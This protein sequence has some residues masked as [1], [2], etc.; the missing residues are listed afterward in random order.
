MPATLDLAALR[1]SYTRAGLT[2]AEAELDPFALFSRWFE[3]AV[4]ARVPEPNAMTLATVG[5]GGQPS[6]RIVLLKELDAEG[7]V[8]Y[9]NYESRKGRDLAAFPHAA[10]VFWWVALE[11]QIRVEGAA[12]RVSAEVSDAYFAARPRG[13]QL[14]AWASEQS[15]RVENREALAARLAELEA[16]F[17][18]REVPRPPHW[19]GYRVRPT[20]LEFWQGRPSRLHDRLVYIR[21][22]DTWRRERLA[23]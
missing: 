20:R 6:A 13:S 16:Q 23:P 19:G 7:F 4:T 5:E 18:N 22:E 21:E 11:R 9:T 2:E 14:G 8:F 17:A 15:R 1:E 3:E 12:E 10:L